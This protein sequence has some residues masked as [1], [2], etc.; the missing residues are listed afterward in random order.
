[1][2]SRTRP[3]AKQLAQV[4]ASLVFAMRELPVRVP[5]SDAPDRER[6][7]STVGRALSQAVLAAT[8]RIGTPTQAAW[9]APGAPLLLVEY[10]T[11]E[12]T[13]IPNFSLALRG[14]ELPEGMQLSYDIL[15]GLRVWCLGALPGVSPQDLRRMR[16]HLLRLHAERE[17]L[18]VV[19]NALADGLLCTDE[20]MPAF[21]RLESYLQNRIG[22]LKRRDVYG[23]DQPLM[24]RM[25][26]GADDLVDEGKRESL[27]EHLRQARVA[28]RKAVAEATHPD[29]DRIFR[30]GGN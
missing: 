14:F 9:L 12:T 13:G 18:G 11:R 29:E 23:H 15:D 22:F 26:F 4:L 10:Q 21:H 24:L 19:L 16:V 6:P 8:T 30:L 1:M 28:T 5:L 27:L 2:V 3:R 20:G 17:S 25:A 7:L